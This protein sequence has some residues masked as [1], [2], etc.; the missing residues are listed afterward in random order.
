MTIPSSVKD[1]GKY[2]FDTLSSL[3]VC[4]SG[5][6]SD[7]RGLLRGSGHEMDRI[8]FKN[9]GPVYSN[10]RIMFD[11]TEG[12]VN[13]TEVEVRAGN[14]IGELPIAERRGY[15]FIGW[16]TAEG[17]GTR[18]T[19]ETIP[20]KSCTVYAQWEKTV[21][22]MPLIA[23]PDG[24]GFRTASCL[25]S[26]DCATADAAI[27]V[28][29]GEV[30]KIA[31]EF[32][33]S[34]PYAIDETSTIY[35]YAVKNGVSS[36]TNVAMITKRYMPTFAEAVSAEGITSFE[37]GGDAGWTVSED[38]NAKV[39]AASVRSGVIGDDEIS[40][41]ST[42]VVGAGTLSFWWK[43][44]CEEDEIK[45][46]D[47]LVFVVDDKEIARLDGVSD[48]QC[49]S[50]ELDS[51]AHTLFWAYEKDGSQ[52]E[53]E[54]CGWVDGIVWTSNAA[55]EVAPTIEG[56]EGVTVTFDAN[57]G[58]GM[59]IPSIQMEVNHVYKLPKC[60]LTPPVNKKRFVGWAC[61]DGRR[62]DDEMLIFNL[63]KPGEK[64]TMTAIWE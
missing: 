33:Y 37:I 35:A 18:V 8:T 36:P 41:F 38:G 19:A 29:I 43:A 13:R 24:T 61:S 64:V 50:I 11:A 5:S 47:H 46:F 42:R 58:I 16:F 55:P 39:G 6:I 59:S 62:Y 15:E 28:G 4:C 34:A 60:T 30:P 56:D 12:I 53:G 63:A 25:V 7:V 45:D 31:A 32:L 51:G 2:A 52:R 49:V 21:V 27:Y 54:D 10:F 3:T 1:I 57:G 48:W 40:W 20:S 44:S 23:P 14:Q 26:I 17:G 9:A 22:T